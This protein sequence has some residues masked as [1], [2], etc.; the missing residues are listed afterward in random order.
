MEEADR[1]LLYYLDLNSRTPIKKLANLTGL[2]PD[3]VDARLKHLKKTGVIRR[4][5]AEIN[6][7]KIGFNTFKVYLQF[8]RTTPEKLDEM[9]EYLASLSNTVWV[10]TCSGRWDMI[11]G[12]WA[13]SVHDFNRTYEKFLTRYHE[14]ILAKETTI[15]VEFCIAN[16]KWLDEEKTR[17]EIVK[18]GGTEPQ[19]LIDDQDFRILILLGMDARMPVISM[20]KELGMEASDVDGRIRNMQKSGVILSYR[21]DIDLKAIGRTFCK[22]FVYL[23]RTSKLDEERLMEYCFRHPEIT[24][25]VR[26][27]GPWD[28]EIEAHSKSFSQF[29]DMMSDMRSRYSALIRSVE[30]V[31]INRETGMMYTPRGKL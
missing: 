29:T 18:V 10:V 19:N 14:Y 31:V 5:F 9:Y 8:Q 16:K 20:A 3:K 17:T 23:S 26:L 7:S 24:T 25:I 28:I 4:C 13:R 27:V 30:A 15:T 1:K 6:R 11:F 21:V 22:S 12:I 2:R